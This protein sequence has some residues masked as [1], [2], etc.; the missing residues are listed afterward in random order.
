VNPT[1][2]LLPSRLAVRTFVGTGP[3]TMNYGEKTELAGA[4]FSNAMSVEE[5]RSL[6]ARYSLDYVYFGPSERALGTPA[7]LSELSEVA[8]TGDVTVYDAKATR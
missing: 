2:L 5:Q 7:V 8:R 4:F 1:G 6:L 3:E